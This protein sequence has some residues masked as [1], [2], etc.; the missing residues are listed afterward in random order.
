MTLIQRIVDAKETA[1]QHKLLIGASLITDG[2][3]VI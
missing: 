2:I 1:N 3:V